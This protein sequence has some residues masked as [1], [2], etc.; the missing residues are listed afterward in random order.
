MLDSS[1]CIDC[2]FFKPEGMDT[3]Y[4]HDHVEGEC[5]RHVPMLGVML[6]DRHGEEFRHF[7]EWPRVLGCDWCGDYQSQQ[8]LNRAHCE[9]HNDCCCSTAKTA[10]GSIDCMAPQAVAGNRE[11]QRCAFR[12]FPIGTAK[13][14]REAVEL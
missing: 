10:V 5:R 2:R 8:K 3:P 13:M 14:A 1:A 11:Q 12:Y 7:G 4:D 6:T 9:F